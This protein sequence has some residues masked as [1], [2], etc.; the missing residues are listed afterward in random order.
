MKAIDPGHLY[1][2]DV[3]DGAWPT[4]ELRFVKRVGDKFPGNAEPA[5]G[6]VLSQEVI[7][8]LID[9]THYVNAQK[10]HHE[11]DIAISGLRS[12]LKAF[13][14]RAAM[15]RGDHSAGLK[16]ALMTEPERWPACAGC[17]HIL[18]NRNHEEV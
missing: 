16:I 17:G 8:A 18:C 13:E 3:L 15:E 10:P 6:G 11:N 4:T 12:A 1:E 7:R 14:I 5:Y 2:L 9:R